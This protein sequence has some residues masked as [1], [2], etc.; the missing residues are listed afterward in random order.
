MKPMDYLEKEGGYYKAHVSHY[1]AKGDEG[2]LATS[3][4]STRCSTTASARS[5]K[6]SLRPRPTGWFTCS[7]QLTMGPSYLGLRATTQ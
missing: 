2:D 6:P 5:P 3:Q 4:N 7:P 1:A